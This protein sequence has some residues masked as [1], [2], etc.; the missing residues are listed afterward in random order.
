M[1][2]SNLKQATLKEITYPVEKV[3][4]ERPANPEYQY[5]VRGTIDGQEI[6]L[7]YCSERYELIPND[8]IFPVIRQILIMHGIQFTE[9][10]YHLNNARFY[11]EF[12]IED[13]RFAYKIPG[14][15]G[16][17]IKPMLKVQHSYNGLTKYVVSFGYFRMV[18][19]NGLVIPVEDMKQYNM[20]VTG[21]HTTAI[22]K[23]LEQLND[24]VTYFAQNAEQITL[25]ITANYSAL[26]DKAVTNVDDRITEVLNV[27]NINIKDNNK[28]STVD[29]I[30]SVIDSEINLFGGVTNDWLVYNAINQYINDDSL[31]V[32][33]PEVRQDMD[34]KVF[35]YMLS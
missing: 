9:K 8:E 11:A 23:S 5:V 7:N 27:A 18:C 34:S 6:D 33:T 32:K 4:N 25:A 20:F 15:N 13:Q 10:Y 16:D 17:V 3:E 24:T 19:S 14:S 21:K 22:K 1:K 31:N 12:I 26:A 29:Y 35:E 30:K 28:F 2:T